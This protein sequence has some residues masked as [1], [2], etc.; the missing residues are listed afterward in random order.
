[1]CREPSEPWLGTPSP[2]V[3]MEQEAKV[4]SSLSH[5]IDPLS[6]MNIIVMLATIFLSEGPSVRQD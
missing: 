1:M 6:K 2:A 3:T 4:R 5:T